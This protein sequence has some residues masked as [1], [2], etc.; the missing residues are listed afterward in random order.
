MHLNIHLKSSLTS[1]SS[2]RLSFA[3][4][5]HRLI[6]AGHETSSLAQ[7]HGLGTAQT[8][9]HRRRSVR[10]S[11]CQLPQQNTCPH[12][13]QTNPA[14]PRSPTSFLSALPTS[15]IHSR[16]SVSSFRWPPQHSSPTF[17]LAL[18]SMLIR[19]I[20]MTLGVTPRMR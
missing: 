20:P 8:M 11:V 16:I 13:P 9:T 18:R 14:S 10:S 5:R 15:P 1:C 17:A 7:W 12:I 4:G 3:T 2:P 19:W 6:W